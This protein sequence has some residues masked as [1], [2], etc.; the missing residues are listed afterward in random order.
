VL[1]MTL[2]EMATCCLCVVLIVLIVNY[3]GSSRH[4][5]IILVLII[6]QD[7]YIRQ[8]YTANS[9]SVDMI[10]PLSSHPMSKTPV[11]GKLVTFGRAQKAG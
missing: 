7:G 8:I 5:R 1:I 4:R 10:A 9:C 3:T 2:A 11:L 6:K